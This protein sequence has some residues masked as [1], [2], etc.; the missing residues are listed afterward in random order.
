MKSKSRCWSSQYHTSMTFQSTNIFMWSLA[1]VAAW[2]C[3]FGISHLRRGHKYLFPK[4]TT[5]EAAIYE[6]LTRVAWSFAMGWV[7]IAC[8]KGHGGVINKFLSWGI[9]Q[10]LAKVSYMV[11]LTHLTVMNNLYTYTRT[12]EEEN[13]HFYQVS[14]HLHDNFTWIDDIFYSSSTHLLVLLP[15]HLLFPW[16]LSYCLKL[17]FLI[18]KNCFLEV[19]MW[20]AHQNSKIPKNIHYV[21]LFFP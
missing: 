12:Y 20:K 2:E 3:V 7:V 19:S 10:P 8:F 21:P 4:W 13:S 17:P 14:L 16:S 11:Y 9:F 5:F 15:S 6:M 1:F 18:F